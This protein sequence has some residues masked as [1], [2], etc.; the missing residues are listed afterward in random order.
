MVLPENCS[1]WISETK[2]STERSLLTKLSSAAQACNAVEN[3][4]LAD[5]CHSN[6]NAESLTMGIS[7]VGLYISDIDSYFDFSQVLGYTKISGVESYPSPYLLS[8]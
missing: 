1:C 7:H 2:T 6:Q 8:L 5:M 3:K 4:L